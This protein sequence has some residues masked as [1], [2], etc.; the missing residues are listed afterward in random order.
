MPDKNEDINLWILHQDRGRNREKAA[1]ETS[2][3]AKVFAGGEEY[4]CA[5]CK[6]TFSEPK[7]VQYYGCPHCLT[8]IEQTGEKEVKVCRYW[9]GFLG[10]KDRNEPVPNECVECDK[11]MDCMLNQYSGS[12]EAVSEIKKWY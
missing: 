11:V 7:L 8:K 10:Q 6:R 5:K 12:P 9:F 3:R 4:R 1:E 2:R